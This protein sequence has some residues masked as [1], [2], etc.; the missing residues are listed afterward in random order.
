[1]TTKIE[2]SNHTIKPEF[3]LSNVIIKNE[4]NNIV[5]TVK[6]ELNEVNNDRH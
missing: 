2:K 5:A 3:T 6:E 1:M 4:D